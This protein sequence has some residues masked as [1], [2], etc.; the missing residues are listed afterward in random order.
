MLLPTI[1]ISNRS[2]LSGKRVK[3]FAV[4]QFRNG[5]TDIPAVCGLRI[6]FVPVPFFFFQVSAIAG[7]VTHKI[8]SSYIGRAVYTQLA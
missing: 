4:F 7:L 6:I 3:I 5:E 2:V 8:V 1:F